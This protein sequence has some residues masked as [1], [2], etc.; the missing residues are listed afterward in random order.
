MAY[1]SA[2]ST[3]EYATDTSC[4]SAQIVA[5]IVDLTR[6]ATAASNRHIPLMIRVLPGHAL[7]EKVL[8]QKKG[9]RPL[10]FS[11]FY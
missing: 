2:P 3:A 6:E 5:P 8:Q 4:S 11:F 10:V 1:D 7:Q 9:D